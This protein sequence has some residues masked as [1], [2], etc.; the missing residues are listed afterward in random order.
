MRLITLSQGG[1]RR[2][3]NSSPAAVFDSVIPQTRWPVRRTMVQSP[4]ICSA[5]FGGAPRSVGILDEQN[6]FARL[7]RLED[8][9]LH[10]AE[11]E[12]GITLRVEQPQEV[13]C[14]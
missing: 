2:T 14:R 11:L 1:C 3:T 9:A 5:V 6:A 7:R 13:V 12:H 8:A 10:L 4:V